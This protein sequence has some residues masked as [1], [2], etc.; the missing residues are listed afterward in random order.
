MSD[1]DQTGSI[2][3]GLVLFAFLLVVGFVA[4]GLI[5]MARECGRHP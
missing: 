3:A 5:L 4:A 1:H 2:L